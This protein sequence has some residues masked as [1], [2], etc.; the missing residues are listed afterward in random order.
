M[1]INT[2][3]IKRQHRRKDINR[4]VLDTENLHKEV[5]RRILEGELTVD[6]L[7]WLENE[8]KYTRQSAENILHKVR[9]ALKD[10]YKQDKEYFASEFNT[11][12]QYLYNEMI[13]QGNLKGAKE[14]LDSQVKLSGLL[15]QDM[16]IS[17]SENSKI[18][19]SFG[20]NKT[21]QKEVNGD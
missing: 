1:Y 16:N 19:I 10:Y 15:N 6:V 3:G 20:F 17:L 8:Q 2:T 7:N 14:T 13:K 21:D 18:T 4:G 5:R 12:Y 9:Q 11:K